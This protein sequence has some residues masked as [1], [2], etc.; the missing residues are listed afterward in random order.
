MDLG[1]I[2]RQSPNG[3]KVGVFKPDR[4][5][6]RSYGVQR[7]RSLHFDLGIPIDY[8]N[9]NDFHGI[10]EMNLDLSITK[11]CFGA[12]RAVIADGNCTVCLDR[13]LAV[14]SRHKN[15]NRSDSSSSF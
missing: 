3:G 7:R 12:D 6:Y 5:S 14:P 11:L 13:F 2:L 4:C 8:H 15:L 1:L 9:K 10:D